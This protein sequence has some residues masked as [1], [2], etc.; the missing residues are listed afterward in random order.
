MAM[1]WDYIKKNRNSFYNKP[2]MAGHYWAKDILD[3]ANSVVKNPKLNKTK[4]QKFIIANSF[5]FDNK[6]DW[7]Y[8]INHIGK[9]Y[10]AQVKHALKKVNTSNVASDIPV[11]V[12]NFAPPGI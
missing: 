12:R 8:F 1:N 6:V 2:Q 3:L 5:R 9:T 7:H 4:I 10:I 11:P